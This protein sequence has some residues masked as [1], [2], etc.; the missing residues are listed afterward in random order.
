MAVMNAARQKAILHEPAIDE[1]ER[2]IELE[3]RT[4]A[5]A[6][7]SDHTS[8]SRDSCRND[9]TAPRLTW[10]SWSLDAFVARTEIE[11]RWRHESSPTCS[12][13]SAQSAQAG[14][15]YTVH[16]PSSPSRDRSP[17]LSPQRRVGSWERK[18][19][20]ATA[21]GARR[22]SAHPARFVH[23][24][25]APLGTHLLWCLVRPPVRVALS[26]SCLPAPGA[27]CAHLAS[28]PESET[29][30][31]R[32]LERATS[33]S[34]C[35]QASNEHR[36]R[37]GERTPTSSSP[38]PVTSSARSRAPAAPARGL[39]RSHRLASSH[40]SSVSSDQARRSLAA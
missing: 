10:L 29:K 36:Q 17:S 26:P 21:L 25:V 1:G 23:T 3:R 33:A 34:R 6:L 40:R 9:C 35:D 27:D 31:K 2:T 11:V 4:S 24:R 30:T 5:D 37:T 18:R 19:N 8:Q 15:R 13:V 32:K 12:R 22:R 39:T 14:A 28:S 16:A 7:Q 20:R 38:R